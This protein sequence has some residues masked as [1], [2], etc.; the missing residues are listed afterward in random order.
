MYFFLFETEGVMLIWQ[1]PCR[2]KNYNIW[3]WHTQINS[4][5]W[6]FYP[7]MQFVTFKISNYVFKTIQ[8]NWVFFPFK[9]SW[10]CQRE[11]RSE[12]VTRRRTDN[13]MVETKGHCKQWSYKHYTENQ[14]YGNTKNQGRGVTNCENNNLMIED[15]I[16]FVIG[17]YT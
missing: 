5:L 9:R 11:D 17:S 10:R 6:F 13:T 7:K 3:F 14:R 12:T 16:V 2:G 4:F 1:L 15:T 8:H